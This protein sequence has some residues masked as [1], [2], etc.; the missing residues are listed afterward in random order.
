MD[1]LRLTLHDQPDAADA[2]IVDD[3]LGAANDAAA[4]LH[5]VRPLACF[6]RADDGAVV[7]G[8]VGRRW[9]ECAELQQLWVRPERRRQGLGARLVRAFEQSAA[10][11]GC[12]RVYLE[13]FSF[14]APSLYRSL[15]YE[16]RHTISGFAPGIHKHL[17]M[18]ELDD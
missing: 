15:G 6:L 1:T 2:K 5:E 4:P 14:Q 3:G 9:G 10:E 8:A 11:A 16:M 12:R 13:T 17:M 18:H 7:G